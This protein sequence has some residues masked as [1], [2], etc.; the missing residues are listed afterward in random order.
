MWYNAFMENETLEAVLKASGSQLALFLT[1]LVFGIISIKLFIKLLKR[2]LLISSMDNAVVRFFTHGIEIILSV[3]LVLYDLSLL[4]IPL[5]SMIAVISAFGVAIGLAIQDSIA[6]VANGLI[7]I[8]TRPFK[9]GDYVQIGSDEG[10]I[11]ELG[12]MNTMLSTIDNKKLILPNRLVS[13]SRILNYNTNP[14][15]RID[16]YFS[17]D[18]DTDV[19]KALVTTKSACLSCKKVLRTPAPRI[20]LYDMA[21]SSLTISAWCWI[22]SHDYYDAFFEIKKAVWDAYKENRITIPFDQIVI[23]ERSGGTT[24]KKT[25]TVRQKTAGDAAKSDGTGR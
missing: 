16:L 18:Y 6:N 1:T 24:R 20:E 12:L 8:G 17:V 9:V 11:E 22:D 13:T 7:M 2:I 3:L 21:S 10:R 14:I 25:Q 19:D 23:S 15:R 4:N 5:T